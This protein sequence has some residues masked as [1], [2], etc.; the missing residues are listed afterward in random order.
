MHSMVK[1]TSDNTD[2]RTHLEFRKLFAM[3][4]RMN[5]DFPTCL[6]G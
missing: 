2:H 4:D 3:F 6:N 1:D 5:D